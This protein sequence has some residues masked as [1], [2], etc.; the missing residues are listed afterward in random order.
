LGAGLQNLRG[1][2]WQKITNNWHER[3]RAETCEQLRACLHDARK[4][5]TPLQNSHKTMSEELSAPIC[6]GDGE[7][8]TLA[9]KAR[10]I[11]LVLNT[12]DLAILRWQFD[13]AM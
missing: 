3:A 10:M 8:V 1:V 9:A 11:K 2:G 7:C 13:Q 12:F 6:A 5:F 4:C